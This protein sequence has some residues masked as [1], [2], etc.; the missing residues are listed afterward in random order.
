M[1]LADSRP[2][3]R[4]GGTWSFKIGEH[5][6][7]DGPAA[8]CGLIQRLDNSNILHTFFARGFR[9]TIIQ[10][11]VREIKKLGSELIAFGDD[12]SFFFP[13]K[14][15]SYRS[16]SAY[17]NA[18]SSRICPFAPTISYEPTSAALKL[19]TNAARQ[20]SLNRNTAALD[21]STSAN[22]LTLH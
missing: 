11:A 18:G 6:D 16:P 15:S 22:F 4:L 9:F 5:R 20:S 14:I 10:Y 17:S 21:S 7:A 3:N 2:S 19:V 13:L 1:W 12:F 8:F